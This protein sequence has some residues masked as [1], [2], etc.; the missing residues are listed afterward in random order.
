MILS[1]LQLPFESWRNGQRDDAEPRQALP[2]AVACSGLR[3]GSTPS[4]S[5]A[6]QHYI[7]RRVAGPYQGWTLGFYVGPYESPSEGAMSCGLTR[8]VGSSSGR[9]T[10]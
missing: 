2:G 3:H 8:T 1:F 6:S 10:A 5:H 4:D 7:I 9:E